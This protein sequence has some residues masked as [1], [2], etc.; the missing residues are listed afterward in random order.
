MQELKMERKSEYILC[1]PCTKSAHQSGFIGMLNFIDTKCH[2][3]DE[4]V[5][6]GVLCIPF[7]TYAPEKG[8]GEGR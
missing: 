1:I 2:W 6:E 8:E 3:C 5:K 4:T 7:G